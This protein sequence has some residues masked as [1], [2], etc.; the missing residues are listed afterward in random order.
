MIT[1]KVKLEASMAFANS[2][3]RNSPRN[4]GENF[5]NGT[6]GRAYDPSTAKDKYKGT[7]GG[8]A[9][10]SYGD[11]WG[12][13][14]GRGT[15]WD[16]YENDYR[17]KET[18]VRPSL[19]LDIDILDWL[20]FNAEGNF[21]YYYT[22]YEEKKPDKG[23]AN[24][25]NSGYYGMSQTSKEQT[26]LNANFMFNKTF[27][28][29]TLNGFV[30]GEYYE[31]FQQAQKLETD[32]GL[33]V[34]NQ[35]FIGNSKNTPK[36][37]GKIEGR[38]KMLSVA[39]QAG[40]SWKDQIFLDV[41][42]RNDWSSALVYAD[43][44]G[45]Y[46]YF[47]PSVNGSWLI[48]S[49][50]RDELPEWIS[51]AKVRGS[52]AQV[53][54]DTSPYTINTAYS[55][56]TSNTLSGSYYGLSVPGTMYD[57]NL[58][59]ERKNAWEIGLDWRFINN[60][61][62]LDATY[63]K[64]NTKNQIMEIAVPYVSGITKQLVNAGN[65]QN[66]GV[67]LALNTIPFQNKDW[68]WTLDFT[69]TKNMNK[70]VE[71]HENVADYIELAGNVGYGNYRIG[72]VAKVGSSYGTLMTDSYMKIDKSSGL[73]MLVWTDSER[74]S[75][76]LRNESEISEIGSM[77]PDFLGSVSTGVKYKNWSLNVSL[78]MRFGGYVASYNSRYGT[79]YGYMETS[80]EGRTGHGGVAWTSAYDGKAYGDGVVPQ[81]IIPAGTNITQPDGSIYTV[82]SGGVSK[83]G[84][85]YQELMNQ[86]VIEPTHASA[87]TFLNNAW[88]QAGVDYGVVNDSWFEKLNYIALRDVSLSYRLPSRAC[89]AI[90][91][92]QCTLTLNGH[93]LGYLL[94]SL[95]N[96]INPESVS[97]TA[98]AEFRIRSLTGVTSSFTFT[99]NVGF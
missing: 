88:T 42:G 21:N 58:K 45:T 51:F 77:V 54:N 62:G 27:G 82:G 57:L 22:R 7:H 71:L 72:S 16:I 43:G 13:M 8:E 55:L 65:I 3:P 94:N 17:Q 86:G 1:P 14:P 6:W 92:K 37:S 40:V 81:G 61:I 53:G 12:N 32:G 20:K 15:W 52:W 47:Y 31:N 59:P 87:W 50:F 74:R 24:I 39:F 95:P 49:T 5:A 73:P 84:Q 80:L 25:G 93:N 89:E 28:D 79:A 60:R 66:Q 23:Y 44:H 68:E 56:N 70:I 64:E 76:Y 83:A 18:S 26:N 9:S 90:K 36:Y 29:F 46:S 33:I 78:D 35:Y 97:G 19:K 85:S 63:Y 48:S 67:E 99:V 34:P 98:A 91:A 10:N 38:K 11:Q 75:H 2:M 69:W 4:I 41:T 96:N 30:R